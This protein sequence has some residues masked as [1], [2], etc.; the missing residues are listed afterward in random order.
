M[1]TA[2]LQTGP[3]KVQ[4]AFEGILRSLDI[5]TLDL[6]LIHWPGMHCS[7]SQ[8]PVLHLDSRIRRTPSTFAIPCPR[9]P[10]VLTWLFGQ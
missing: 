6:L 1:L 2:L 8:C 4:P 7:I 9:C 3:G 10:L 5:Q